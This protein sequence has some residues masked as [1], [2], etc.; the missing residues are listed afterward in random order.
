MDHYI[1]SSNHAL[2]DFNAACTY[3][4]KRGFQADHPIGCSIV[5][6]GTYPHYIG[7]HERPISAVVTLWE[8]HDQTFSL[9]VQCSCGVNEEWLAEKL[10]QEII[11]SWGN[12]MTAPR[13]PPKQAS[14]NCENAR[15]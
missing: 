9:L 11:E 7:A 15:N 3:L 5:F 13:R 6:R 2:A 4:S 1:A 14:S 10:H 8:K 12:T